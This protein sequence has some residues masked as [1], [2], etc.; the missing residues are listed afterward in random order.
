[1]V[2]P[3]LAISSAMA[4]LIWDA[5]N[6]GAPAAVQ[7]YALPGVFD[8]SETGPRDITIPAHWRAP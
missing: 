8:R 6:R 3:P 7:Q 5:L 2:R 1:M 4:Q